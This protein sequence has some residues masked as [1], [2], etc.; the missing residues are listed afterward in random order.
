MLESS[1]AY[2]G[3]FALDLYPADGIDFF[4]CTRLRV[5]FTVILNNTESMA[6]KKY[7]HV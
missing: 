1:G 4:G 7:E 3:I 2:G 6:E 5:R